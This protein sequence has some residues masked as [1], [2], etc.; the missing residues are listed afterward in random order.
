MREYSKEVLNA[1]VADLQ[2]TMLAAPPPVKASVEPR[3]TSIIDS[4]I[5]QVSAMD[6]YCQ[7][8]SVN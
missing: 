3:P 7:S 5:A 1:A 6:G 8:H 4:L 2:T